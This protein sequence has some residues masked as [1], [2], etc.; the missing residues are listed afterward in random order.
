MLFQKLPVL[1]VCQ[2]LPLK[3]REGGQSLQNCNKK[4]AIRL[5][6]RF[7]NDTNSEQARLARHGVRVR[8]LALLHDNRCM[9]RIKFWGHSDHGCNRLESLAGKHRLTYRES[10]GAQS[11]RS[12]RLP[13]MQPVR[14]NFENNIRVCNGFGRLSNS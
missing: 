9:K 2:K 14:H 4:P 11:G 6:S 5:D 3:A 1:I 10:S 7:A 13:F 8:L 12:Q